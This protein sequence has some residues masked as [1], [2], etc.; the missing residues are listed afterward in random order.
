MRG[1]LIE[2]LTQVVEGD[3]AEEGGLTMMNEVS[4]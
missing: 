1:E 4:Q 3:I 2:I